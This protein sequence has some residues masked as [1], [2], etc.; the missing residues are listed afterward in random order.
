[1]NAYQEF[2]IFTAEIPAIPGCLAWG[3]TLE[4]TYQNAIEAIESCLEEREKVAAIDL[5]KP[6]FGSVNVYRRPVN[7]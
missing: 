3:E 1:M 2:E 6:R 7:A 5:P 4:Q